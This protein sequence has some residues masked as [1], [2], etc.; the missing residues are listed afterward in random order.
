[1]ENSEKD[2]IKLLSL[3]ISKKYFNMEFQLKDDDDN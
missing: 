3:E 1:M 2:L